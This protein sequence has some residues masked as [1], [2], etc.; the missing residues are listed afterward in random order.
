[1]D[2]L[3]MNCGANVL[4]ELFLLAVDCV[5]IWEGIDG[6]EARGENDWFLEW[7]AF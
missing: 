4:D 5:R 7:P 1:M 2:S 3:L 6:E